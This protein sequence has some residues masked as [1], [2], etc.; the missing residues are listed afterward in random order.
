MAR[1]LAGAAFLLAQVGVLAALLTAPAFHVGAIDV[2][3]ERLLSRQAVLAAARI[4]HSSLFTVDGDAIESRIA[5]LSWV[6]TATV[7][8][9]LPS[10]IRIDVTEWQPDVLLRHGAGATFVAANGATL[11]LTQS[12]SAVRRGIPVLLDYLPG[13]Q[14]ALQPGLA[15]LLAS[16]AQRWPSVFGCSVDAFVLSSSNV[17]SVWSS[18]GWQAVF[19]AIDGGDALAALPDQI[20]V[21]A[22][23]KVRLDFVHPTFGYVDL[24]NPAA[25]AT[26]GKPG[27]PAALRSAIAGGMLP[28]SPP[29][30]V[31]EPP[32][33]VS[34]TPALS[35]TPT[36]APTPLPT[37]SAAVF[38]LAPPSPS[39]HR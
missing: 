33:A 23:L 28:T 27:E 5:Q 8:T 7:T 19:G 34:P 1:R 9:Q 12:T 38:S 10:T 39:A 4:P 13:P 21:L 18:T 30:A 22:A 2:S 6:R 15:G 14:R 24:E 26:G 16:A 20:A 35:P 36:P 25:P 29:A 31:I 17:L 3:G 37:P 32:V 11:P